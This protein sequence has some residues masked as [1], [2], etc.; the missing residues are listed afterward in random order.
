LR[1]N[2]DLPLK[3]EEIISKA[4]EKD[5]DLPYQVAAEMRADLKTVEARN[6]IKPTPQ[7]VSTLRR[8]PP[9]RR[10]PPATHSTGVRR[11]LRGEATQMGCFWNCGA[12]LTVLLRP[13]SE[14]YSLLAVQAGLISRISR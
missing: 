3:L 4:L 13:F 10:R 6:R 7:P 5:R 2:P 12:G 1:L 8:L 11:L 9:Y 14:V